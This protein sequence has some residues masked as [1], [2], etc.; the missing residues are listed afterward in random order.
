MAAPSPSFAADGVL[1][2]SSTIHG[3]ALDENNQPVVL[4]ETNIARAQ[5]GII[6]SLRAQLDKASRAQFDAAVK[7]NADKAAGKPGDQ[8][9]ANAVAIQ[10]LIK[11]LQPEDAGTLQTQNLKLLTR[12]GGLVGKP[13]SLQDLA[14]GKRPLFSDL[15]PS[16]LL[17]GVNPVGIFG[18]FRPFY[19]YSAKCQATGVPVP[20]PLNVKTPSAAWKNA[21]EQK[22]SYL[23]PPVQHPHKF[24]QM[25]YYIPA[26]GSGIC[27][28][29]PIVEDNAAHPNSINAFGVICQ[30][31]AKPGKPS[32][33][34]FWD[35]ATDSLDI[36]ATHNFNNTA[37]FNAPPN[38]PNDN[39]CTD[40][41]SGSHAYIIMPKIGIANPT[42]EPSAIEEAIKAYDNGHPAANFHNQDNWFTP[43]VQ[44]NWPQ[45]AYK[46]YPAGAA[47]DPNNGA[48]CGGCHGPNGGFLG[49]TL[50][51]VAGV[52]LPRDQLFKFCSF[53]LPD[54]LT[55]VHDP[56]HYYDG[57]MHTQAQSSPT[58]ATALYTACQGIIPGGYFPAT[59]G[60]WL[61]HR[62]PP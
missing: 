52:V 16:A 18:P 3:I 20:P 1:K 45:N 43:L 36:A 12:Y 14:A 41:H 59:Q 37:E 28:A 19:T 55:S 48:S 31:I 32:H 5:A 54:F 61:V 33:A 57:A 13:V 17:N 40:C 26:D 27:V 25:F 8:V 24:S 42:L 50:P 6:E 46:A 9:W 49:K 21:G 58:G 15:S 53:I 10:S 4:D 2:L 38:L 7:A 34:C 35:N 44:S 23:E 11:K 47:T 39:Q 56:A 30:S 51:E 60:A 22:V 29:N 62:D